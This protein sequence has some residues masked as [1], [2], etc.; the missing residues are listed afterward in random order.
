MFGGFLESITHLPPLA[1][2]AVALIVFLTVPA[3]C[4][5]VRLPAVV[6]LLAAGVVLGPSGL[7]VAPKHGEV[8]Q[9]FA[10]I[11][12]L[13]LMFF[14]GLELDLVQFQQVRNRSLAFGVASF[15]FPIVM[16]TALG[17]AFGYN[18]LSAL[19]IGS[20][21]AS[22]TLLGYPI[23]Q[24]LGLVRNEAVTVTIGATI[25]TDV[26]ALLVVAVC[27]PIHTTGFSPAAFV[28]Q[29]VELAIYVPLVLF[30]LSYGAHALMAHLESSKE[31][32]LLVMLLIVVVAAIAAEA[33]H[34]EGIIGAFLAGL[35]VNR[36]IQHSPAKEELEF[37][38][39]TLFIPAFFVTIGF[40]IDVRV[41]ADTIANNLVLVGGIV[42]TPVVAKWLA[43]IVTQKSLGYT[44]DEGLI[45]WALAL[46][47]V[48][49]TLAVALTAYDAKNAAGVRLIDEPV[50]NS[51]IVLMVVTSVL[52]PVL[53]EVYGQR[54]A[55]KSVGTG[56]SD[57]GV[58]DPANG[59]SVTT[60][61]LGS[62]PATEV[63][64]NNPPM[65]RS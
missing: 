5:K 38:G 47:Q 26:A 10:D 15:A 57:R 45:M 17:L 25:F 56:A 50:L 31:G 14:A 49:A 43:G 13:L 20:V 11:G 33:I 30:V 58:V 23:V 59:V 51:V 34:L 61:V 54:I 21:F 27:I 7:H 44:R 63:A 9:F 19:L 48:A 36:A 24:R 46:P 3:L 60:H 12:K 41:F 1:R 2:F 28:T 32:Q 37:L 64:G 29:L 39:N 6:G 62:K 18:W 65:L 4:R 52:G 55:A 35:A 8:A 53:T 42:A 40:L 16:G 22:H